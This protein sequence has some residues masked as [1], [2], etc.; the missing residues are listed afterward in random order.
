MSRVNLIPNN[1]FTSVVEDASREID[2]LKTVQHIGS[3][4]L[5]TYNNQTEDT[6]DV[7]AETVSGAA[8]T[9]QWRVIFTPDHLSNVF[10]TF[11]SYQFVTGS[12]GDFN[13]F[14]HYADPAY[15]DDPTQ[16]AYIVQFNN[17]NLTDEQVSIKFGFVSTDTGTISW[18][19]I[20]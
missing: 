1:R 13:E 5:I 16:T 7:N 14:I 12:A 20:L 15:A 10:A 19:R 18:S 2:N 8:L 6:W 11:A 4:S 3:D 9:A 17:P